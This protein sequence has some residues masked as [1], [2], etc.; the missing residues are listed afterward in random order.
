M[1]LLEFNKIL[2][3]TGIPV[4]YRYFPADD[5]KNP[6]PAPPFICYFETNDN[7]F[8]AD[9]IVYKKIANIAVELYTEKKD[10]A[11]EEKVEK[12]LSSFFWSK[13][14]E[15]LKDEKCYFVVYEMEVMIDE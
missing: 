4:A 1:T 11:S 13:D 3:S 9:G 15:Y 12:A 6:P 7:N 2:Q 5:P 8:A 14:E 10:L